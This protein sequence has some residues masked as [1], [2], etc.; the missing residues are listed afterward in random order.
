MLGI[1]VTIEVNAAIDV[2]EWIIDSGS[3]RHICSQKSMFKTLDKSPRD[4]VYL[5]DASALQV[6]GIE[7]VALKLFSG[8]VLTLTKVLFVPNMCRNLISSTLL[9]IAEFKQTLEAG[10][11]V[12]TKNGGYVGKAFVMEISLF[13][14]L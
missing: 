13:L 7:E 1:A 3:T 11:L 5:G 6:A 12:I 14:R 8:R 4:S 9:M 10:K 2:V